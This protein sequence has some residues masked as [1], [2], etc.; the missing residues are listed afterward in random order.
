M[1]CCG[2]AG[3]ALCKGKWV[4]QCDVKHYYSIQVF[5]NLWFRNPVWFRFWVLCNVP[6][7]PYQTSDASKLDAQQEL[8]IKMEQDNPSGANL[9]A[10]LLFS[11]QLQL[12]W[13]K[14]CGASLLFVTAIFH[15]VVADHFAGTLVV[16]WV[17]SQGETWN[18]LISLASF[19]SW[20]L[21][22]STD[23][24]ALSFNSR[25]ALS[26]SASLLV[27]AARSV[28]YGGSWWVVVPLTL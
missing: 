16:Y 12:P 19:E 6:L 7:T 5:L 4:T 23:L 20:R 18:T 3:W 10:M 8:K 11:V 24:C 9:W 1:S 14:L 21:G 25:P 13:V 22:F 26:F 28:D 17:L 27:T 15:V 2:K